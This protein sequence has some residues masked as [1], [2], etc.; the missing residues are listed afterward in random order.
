MQTT[1]FIYI[2]MCVLFIL[3]LVAF[4]IKRIVTKR[5]EG[6]WRIKWPFLGFIVALS[7]LLITFLVMAYQTTLFTR[8]EIAAERY[9]GYHAEYATG[10]INLEEYITATDK[11][12]V[13]PLEP[14]Q[15]EALLALAG[16]PTKAVRF[17]FGDA[18]LPEKYKD[19]AE[20]AA[21]DLVDKENPI[22]IIYSIDNAKTQQY[23]LICLRW[24]ETEG[25][26]VLEHIAAPENLGQ[27]FPGI[28]QYIPNAKNGKWF[29]I[30][31]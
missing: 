14:G 15:A 3:P 10:K 24:T 5:P 27:Q 20:L 4:N 25:W 11:L 16:A 12:R 9:I 23:Y 28:S 19:W 29:Y 18:I 2:M 30:S 13:E 22:W 8:Y 26:K 21:V 7:A 31:S 6:V 1:K 17:Q